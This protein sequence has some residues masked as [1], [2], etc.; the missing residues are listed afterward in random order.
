MHAFYAR[1]V[2]AIYQPVLLMLDLCLG[3]KDRLKQGTKILIH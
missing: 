3:K 2:K 1:N